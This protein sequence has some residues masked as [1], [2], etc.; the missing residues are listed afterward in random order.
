MWWIAYW[1]SNLSVLKV[2]SRR[3]PLFLNYLKALWKLCSYFEDVLLIW[4][5]EQCP[6]PPLMFLWS[7]KL[8]AVVWNLSVLISP[9]IPASPLWLSFPFFPFGW[10]I[11]YSCFSFTPGVSTSTRFEV[12]KFNRSGVKKKKKLRWG[13][14][15]WVSPYLDERFI[16][17]HVFLRGQCRGQISVKTRPKSVYSFRIKYRLL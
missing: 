7:F 11:Y 1:I 15:I 4:S 8:R 16:L 3:V 2:G 9:F 17:G 13:N 12:G 6:P 5:F 10:R 14:S